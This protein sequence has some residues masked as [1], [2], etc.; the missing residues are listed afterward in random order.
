MSSQFD[1]LRRELDYL[2]Y[3]QKLH[4]ECIPLV[5]KL[6]GDLDITT[7]NL[8][9]YMKISQYALEEKDLLESAAEPYK[10]D[11]AK[12]IKECNDLHLAFIHF[13]E[14]HERIQRDLRHQLST[15]QN[16]LDNCNLEKQNLV[17]QIQQ[18]N[19]DKMRKG[20]KS[21]EMNK[22]NTYKSISEKKVSDELNDLKEK[23]QKVVQDNAFLQ[24]QL[25]I[26][27]GEIQRLHSVSQGSRSLKD[28]NSECCYKNFDNKLQLL[29]NEISELKSEKNDLQIQAEEALAKQHEAMRRA[30]HLLERNKQL[31]KEIKETDAIALAVESQWNNSMK[32]TSQRVVKLQEEVSESITKIKNM[33]KENT[34]LKQTKLKLTT[35]LEAL[36]LEKAHIQK[37]LDFEV[38]DKKKLTDKINNMTVIENDLN[39]EIDRLTRLSCEQK[40]KIVELE[41]QLGLQREGKNAYSIDTTTQADEMSNKISQTT[42]PKGTKNTKQKA[43]ASK[44]A[45]KPVRN[46]SPIKNE[47]LATEHTQKCCC[48]SGNCIKGFKEL[49]EKEREFREATANQS[50]ENLKAE[51][52]YFMKEYHKALEQLRNVPVNDTSSSIIS[53]LKQQLKDKEAVIMR[54]E[55]EMQLMNRERSHALLENVGNNGPCNNPNCKR[56]QREMEILRDDVRHSEIE[57]NTLKAKLQS[58]N[59][60]TVFNEERMKKAF[61]EM[62]AHIRKLEDE[63]RELV[64]GELTQRSSI[65]H[66]EDEYKSVKEQ[67]RQA[68]ME[69]STLRASYNQL[70]L[71]NEQADRALADA[72]SKMLHAE[73]ELANYHSIMKDSHRETAVHD[74]EVTR[75][76]SDLQIMKNQLSKLDREKDDILNKLDEKTEQNAALEDQLL[77]KNKALANLETELKELRRKLSKFVDESSS[78]EQIARSKQQE[79]QLLDQ[80]LQ[81]ERRLKEAALLEN[82][83]L[84]NELS[85][86]TADCRDARNELEIC[87]RQIEDLKRQLQQYVAEVKR[88]EDLI[89]QK[90]YERSELLDQ[91]KSLS[92]EHDILENNN[93]TLETEATQSRIQLSVALDHTSELERRIQNQESV[94]KS[95]EKQ[96]T[97]LTSQVASLEIQLKQESMAQE[98]YNS[99]LRQM[100]DLC[101]KL[102]KDKDCLRQELTGKEDIRSQVGKA[103]E[104]LRSEKESLEKALE[105]ERASLEGVEQLLS[106]ARKEIMDQRLLNQDLQAEVENLKERINELQDRLN[107]NEK[108]GDVLTTDNEMTKYLLPPNKTRDTIEKINKVPKDVSPNEKKDFKTSKE[109]KDKST[110]DEENFEKSG[111]FRHFEQREACEAHC[112]DVPENLDPVDDCN[113]HI[114]STCTLPSAL[115]SSYHGSDG[116]FQGTIDLSKLWK[117]QYHQLYNTK[118]AMLHQD[119]THNNLPVHASNGIMKK[120]ASA[121]SKG[122]RNRANESEDADAQKHDRCRCT[123]CMSNSSI[124]EPLLHEKSLSTRSACKKKEILE[125]DK[126]TEREMPVRG[127]KS[128]VPTKT[129]TRAEFNKSSDSEATFHKVFSID[130]V[131]LE[132]RCSISSFKD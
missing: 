1:E 40:R 14:Q 19:R 110:S 119:S 125:N 113:D 18:L 31:E 76:T 124:S 5:K 71:L 74:R 90:E 49:L 112:D 53:D 98:R 21:Q 86:V 37:Q 126:K 120:K 103:S 117:D 9:K 16:R 28:L 121:L 111:N 10:C 132:C 108:N 85:S 109:D 12:L 92:Q 52:E 128:N 43:E 22:E 67:L 6:L 101:V 46:K 81:K 42:K 20:S 50:L 8:Q 32:C 13:K 2:G 95:Y 4:P 45:K 11:N 89:S 78:K 24:N 72:Q 130:G 15:L 99:E 105:K 131:G 106:E 64:K 116:E 29:Q 41:A 91:F 63:R 114:L 75:L 55:T 7:T 115:A 77:S 25:N 44:G 94:I 122:V 79:M 23:Y 56:R 62:E 3:P 39:L 93:H 102:D 34:S 104:M 127:E 51:K 107:T 88:T 60:T 66:L 33:E 87:K 70:K 129:K 26:R 100:R 61:Q 97:D 84:Q 47:S 68:Q 65:S 30:L 80:D 58:V 69:L 82:K 57:S 96:I 54:L 27:D 48:G 59:E 36:R 83:R 35:E 38:E 17:K 123:K 118:N 73:T